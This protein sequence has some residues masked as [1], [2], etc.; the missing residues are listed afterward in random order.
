MSLDPLVQIKE[1]PLITPAELAQ[2]Y[3]RSLANEGLEFRELKQVY[4]RV[5][6]EVRGYSA[7]CEDTEGSQRFGEFVIQF[8][9][10]LALHNMGSAAKYL[11]DFAD[12]EYL[13][14][15]QLAPEI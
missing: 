10:S 12:S 4:R 3:F 14:A 5:R 9:R 2:A 15:E 7:R 1:N 13:E 6:D 8:K 11:E